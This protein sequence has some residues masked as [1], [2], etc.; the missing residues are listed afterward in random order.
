[1]TDL[2]NG[3]KYLDDMVARKTTEK[4]PYGTWKLQEAVDGVKAMIASD[5]SG[6][7]LSAYN[8]SVTNAE[9]YIKTL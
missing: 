4:T 7:D 9:N 3:S 8:T 5:K 6:N 2:I 1:M